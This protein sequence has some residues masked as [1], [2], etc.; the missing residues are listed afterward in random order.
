MLSSCN[1]SQLVTLFIYAHCC[2]QPERHSLPH[3]RVYLLD[4]AGLIISGTDAECGDDTAALIIAQVLVDDGFAVE[5]WTGARLVGQLRP[6]SGRNSSS[7]TS[8]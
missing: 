5:I 2:L 1:K 3:Y 8:E 6:A 4:T 7:R